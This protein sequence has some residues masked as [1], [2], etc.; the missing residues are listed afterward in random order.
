[1]PGPESLA[2]RAREDAHLAP[3][4]Q[5][6]AVMAGIV[7]D[8]AA[9]QRGHRRRR[10]H[11][12]RLHRR[13]RRQ[14]ARALAPDV[15]RG[16]AGAGREGRRS[17]RFT[18]R[19]RV[20]LL[21]RLAAQPPAP[22]VHRLQLYSGGAEAVESA[23]RLAKCHT[24]KYEFVSFW[25]GFHGKTL[26]ALSLMGSTFKDELGP[27][28]AASHL[29]PYA[30]C[31]RCP[32][33][34]SYPQLRHRLRRGRAQARSRRRRRARSPRVDRRADAGHGRQR[35]PAQGVPAGGQVD[36][37]RARR[38]AH[39]RRDDHRPRPHRHAAG[40]STTPAS[41]PTSSRSARRSAAGFR[42]RGCSP[43]TRFSRAKPWANPSGSSSSYGGNPLAA[44]AGAAAL[45]IIDEERLVENAR[46]VG[47][48]DAARARGLRR[49]LSRSSASCRARACSCASSW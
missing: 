39:R 30:D 46:D 15:R 48:G 14:R 31:Y 12:P 21:E 29:V 25:G 43:P 38:A 16:A 49:P 1:M 47:R 27:M 17:A 7:V 37:R 10:K 24:G 11:L 4:L 36:R 45:R 32:V 20:E 6:Y 42:C 40:A 3:G 28:A 8:K 2:L 9:G 34:L 41:S 22:G 44:A 19:A 18:S 13:H 33:G 35:H 26:G 23:L 5:G